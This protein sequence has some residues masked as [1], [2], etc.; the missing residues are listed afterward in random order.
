VKKRIRIL[1]AGGL[2]ALA[3]FGAAAAGPLEDGVAAYQRHD[4]AVAMRLLRPL[5]EQG[6]AVAQYN[7]GLIYDDGD[8]VPQDYAA[9]RAWY[10]KACA[11]GFA[12]SQ[13]NL[14]SM[15]ATGHG[16]ARDPAQAV[17]WY[18]KA[19]EQG[20]ATA[21]YNLGVMYQHGQGVEQDYAQAHM[22]FSLAASSAT[23]GTETRDGAAKALD[24]LAAKMTHAEIGEAQRMARERIPNVSPQPPP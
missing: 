10:L 7:I 19:A 3:S 14:G 20:D 16:V 6:N 12:P 17:T 21:Q 9:A 13:N 23:A 1:L 24:E 18:L 2:L 4:Y 22:W 11:Q 15:Y 8:G 5:A